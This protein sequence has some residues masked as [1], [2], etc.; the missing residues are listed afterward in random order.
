MRSVRRVLS[1]L[2]AAALMT[3][4]VSAAG[5]Q[6]IRSV[7]FADANIGYMGGYNAVGGSTGDLGFISVTQDGGSTWRS[8]RLS[9][10]TS[11]I[12]SVASGDGQNARAVAKYDPFPYKTGNFGASWSKTAAALPGD[13]MQPV[14]VERFAGGRTVAVGTY[15]GRGAGDAGGDYGVIIASENGDTGWTRKWAGPEYP[16]VGEGNAKVTNADMRDVDTFGTNRLVGWAV[17]NERQPDTGGDAALYKEILV[18]KTSDGGQTWVKQTPPAIVGLNDFYITSVVAVSDTVAFAAGSH[19]YVMKTV[20]GGTSWTG[21]ALPTAIF[22]G[23]P[24]AAKAFNDIAAVDANTVVAVGADGWIART[25]NGG[26]SWTGIQ[27]PQ[28][29]TLRSV[30]VVTATK[31]IAA[32]DDEV[33]YRTIDGGA[34]WTTVSSGK[35]APTVAITAPSAGFAM[36]TGSPI[37]IMG[38]AADAG[39]GVAGAE[40][41]IKR[42]DGRYFDGSTWVTAE[43]WLTA[44]SPNGGR[45]WSYAWTPD[46]TTVASGQVW[47]RARAQDGLRNYASPKEIASR[48]TRRSTGFTS[49]GHR[50]VPAY[51][52]ASYLSGVLISGTAKLGGRSVTLQRM[53]NR[54]SGSW[55]NVTSKLTDSAGYVKFDI[56]ASPSGYNYTK[57]IY[58]LAYNGAPGYSPSQSANRTVHP[59]VALGKPWKSAKT[60]K[61]KKTFTWYS[62]IKP[63]HAAGS[64]A[65][66]LEFQRYVKG[67]PRAYKTVSATAYNH[68]TYSRAKVKIKLPYKGTW[69][70]RAVHSD[71]GHAKSTS[72]WYKFTVK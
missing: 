9:G 7:S 8:V 60:I 10:P 12:F 61:A 50:G 56:P 72:A 66:K 52:Q 23:S 45:N 62:W 22:G 2:L 33:V 63:R 48:N 13:Q 64:K 40:V 59:K 21:Q 28:K 25:A 44:S 4:V 37:N 51:N 34:T 16:A 15:D 39:V 71:T 32:G 53:A 55:V 38:T 17:G 54:T 3:P 70:V 24:S 18:F 67:K 11:S 42:A 26:T 57:T 19:K 31:W 30:A 35:A 6:S 65:L 29:K 68:S 46:S 20:N 41:S 5:L 27:M 49:L 69:R 14:A 1:V 58:R 47:V 36:S 43:K